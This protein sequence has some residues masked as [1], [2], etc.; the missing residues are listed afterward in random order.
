M[1]TFDSVSA[2]VRRSFSSLSVCVSLLPQKLF[3]EF[4][5]LSGFESGFCV[6]TVELS[7]THRSLCACCM[8]RERGG[9]RREGAKQPISVRIK[10]QR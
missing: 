4:V 3:M 1:V 6:R 2:F 7:V 8:G 5:I 9:Q 10:V